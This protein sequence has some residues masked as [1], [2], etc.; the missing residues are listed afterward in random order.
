ME[1]IMNKLFL[2][3]IASDVFACTNNTEGTGDEPKDMGTKTEAVGNTPNNNNGGS[4]TTPT[5]NNNAYNTDSAS[6]QGT[7]YDTASNNQKK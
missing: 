1:T 2:V 6:G 4:D 3:L 7:T 5:T